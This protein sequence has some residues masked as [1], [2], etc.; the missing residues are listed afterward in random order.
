MPKRNKRKNNSNST[1]K[2]DA[3]R[4][5]NRT[6][7]EWACAVSFDGQ[8]GL[9]CETQLFIGAA[10]T[11]RPVRRGRPARDTA[12]A[13]KTHGALDG[14]A[15]DILAGV[16]PAVAVQLLLFRGVQPVGGNPR[17]DLQTRL[18]R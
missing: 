8:S 17:C 15:D 5:R 13:E 6:S 14:D 12:L 11:R 2:L 3:N 4:P 7:T 16:D 9:A 1:K 18:R 10:S